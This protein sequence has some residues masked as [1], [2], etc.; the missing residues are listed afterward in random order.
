[1]CGIIGYVGKDNKAITKTISCLEKLE[2]RGYDSAGIAYI[3]NNQINIVKEQ[4]RIK[5]LKDKLDFDLKL[6]M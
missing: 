5:K 6:E 2:Y 1:M 3:S 4:G